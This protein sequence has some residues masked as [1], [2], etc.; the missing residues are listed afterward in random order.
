MPYALAQ[1]SARATT[2]LAGASYTLE[3]GQTINA[4]FLRDNHGFARDVERR[5]FALAAGLDAAIRTPGAT[6]AAAA[7]ALGLALAN[8]PRLLGRDYLYL[9]WQSNP[10][11]GSGYWRAGWTGNLDDHSGQFTLYGELNVAERLTVFAVLTANHGT[12]RSDFASLS[13]GAATVGA[14]LFV[15]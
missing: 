4:E 6:T 8:A 12:R 14:K 15:F 11:E 13:G 1:P 2:A 10:N 7:A 9:L 3:S 5:D